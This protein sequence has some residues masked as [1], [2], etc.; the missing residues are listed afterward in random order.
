MGNVFGPDTLNEA[1]FKFLCPFGLTD[2][3]FKAHYNEFS[4]YIGPAAFW[5]NVALSHTN[6]VSIN[7]I[8][9]RYIE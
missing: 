1:C 9:L 7:C 5:G 2:T 6:G 4:V 3:A 8:W